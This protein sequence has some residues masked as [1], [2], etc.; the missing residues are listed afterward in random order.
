MATSTRIAITLTTVFAAAGCGSSEVPA[1]QMAETGAAIR[2]SAEIGAENNPQAAL[3]LKLAKDRYEQAQALSKDG[4]QEA[5]TLALEKA[6]ADADLALA[7]TR[8]EQASAK[9]EEAKRKLQPPS[10]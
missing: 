3:H 1:K 5:A 2:A 6:E 9:A 8:K 10:Q 4:E 7:L